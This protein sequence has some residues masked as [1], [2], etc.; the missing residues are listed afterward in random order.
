MSLYARKWNETW[1]IYTSSRDGGRSAIAFFQFRVFREKVSV[2]IHMRIHKPSF[3]QVKD[4]ITMMWLSLMH[5]PDSNISLR[6]RVNQEAI[7]V[8]RRQLMQ[9][10]QSYK[11]VAAPFQ[12]HWNIY[13]ALFIINVEYHL[14]YILVENQNATLDISSEYW[15]QCPEYCCGEQCQSA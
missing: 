12:E 11:R 1:A 8:W 15:P 7:F 3:P 13:G 5:F 9:S 6:N 14:D 4:C 10:L 2:S